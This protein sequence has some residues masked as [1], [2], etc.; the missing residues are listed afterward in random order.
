MKPESK[1]LR[2]AA[3]ITSKYADIILESI[4]DGVF[5]VDSEWRITSFNRAAVEITRIARE[6]AIGR[7][8]FDVF[9]ANMCEIGCPLRQTM[10]TGRPI[11]NRSAFI[12][13]VTGQKVPISISTGLLKN[14]EGAVIGGGESFRDLTLVEKLRKEIQGRFQIGDLISRSEFLAARARYYELRGWTP[15]GRLPDEASA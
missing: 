5:T 4:S 13:D 15:A 9:K 8:C 11:I 7:F 2:P 1:P 10:K 6:E 3:N 14:E 12:V